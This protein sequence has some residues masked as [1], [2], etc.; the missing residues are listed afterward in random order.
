MRKI[1]VAVTAAAVI[2]VGG[3][4]LPGG[5]AA[6]PSGVCP[7]GH[8]PYFVFFD[9]TGKA[10]QK[11]RNNN[12]VVCR[13]YDPNNPFTNVQGGPDDKLDEADLIDD[14]PDA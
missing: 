11:D 10:A 13:K 5:A 12:G 3:L 4:A 9:Q 1:I 7:N 8:Q 14:I 6:D 2:A